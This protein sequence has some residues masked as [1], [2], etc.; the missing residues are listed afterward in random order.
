V[1]PDYNMSYGKIISLIPARR[2]SKGIKNKNIHEI[3]CK[4]LIAYSINQSLKSKYIDRTIVST[5]SEEII[6][7]AKKYGAET[8]FVR[9]REL[10]TDVAA[11][12]DV[13]KH[14]LSFLIEEE[15]YKPEIVVILQ[16]TSPLRTV[17]IIDKSIELLRATGGDSVIS[18]S[19]VK[20]HPFWL[21]KRN[22]NRIIPYVDEGLKVKRRQDLP[23]LYFV[24]GMIYTVKT[25]VILE[26]SSVFGK[27]I[28]PLITPPEISIDIDNYLDMFICEMI[29][30]NWQNW[31]N[32][33]RL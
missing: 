6:K 24:N 9:P 23:E 31:Q 1:E 17:E 22:D 29:M 25:E 19:K 21:F 5:D 7:I 14:A 16:P 13:F 2:G 32:E 27:D 4:P 10:A 11:S 33:N 15:K 30:K 28:I 3:N 12:V 18:V 20:E 26:Q 8:P